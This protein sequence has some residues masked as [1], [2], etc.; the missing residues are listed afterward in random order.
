[1]EKL[2]KTLVYMMVVFS[3]VV[4]YFYDGYLGKAHLPQFANNERSYQP[5][6]EQL[7]R[8]R[9]LRLE[10]RVRAREEIC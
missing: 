7:S 5:T 8:A 6:E 1:M 4:T 2:T 10:D 9:Q 3:A